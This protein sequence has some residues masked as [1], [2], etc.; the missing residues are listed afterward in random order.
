MICIYVAI[1]QKASTV[2][3]VVSNW[4]KGAMD[5]TI[6]VSAPASEPAPCFGAPCRRCHGEYLYITAKQY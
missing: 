1:G 2:S 6:V 4:K 3:S 5:Y